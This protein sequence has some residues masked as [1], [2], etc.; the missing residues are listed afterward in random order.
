MLTYQFDN[1]SETFRNHREHPYTVCLSL[2][3]GNDTTLT[4]MAKQ[5]K[6][7]HFP[8]ATLGI[9]KAFR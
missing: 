8:F 7:I 4:T 2:K 6:V 3:I 9:P 5:S 1:G